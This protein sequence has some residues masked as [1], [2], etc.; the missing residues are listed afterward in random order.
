MAAV[1]ALL[2]AFGVIAPFSWFIG[3]AIGGSLYYGFAKGQ[4]AIPQPVAARSPVPV[5]RT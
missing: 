3:V 5:T 4:R 2:P 1:F